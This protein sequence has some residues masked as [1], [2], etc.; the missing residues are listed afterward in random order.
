VLSTYWR[1][2]GDNDPDKEAPQLIE[3]WVLPYLSGNK[4]KLL[5][6]FLQ[7]GGFDVQYYYSWKPEPKPYRQL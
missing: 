1:D 5:T 2:F 3:K 4:Q 7:E 6:S